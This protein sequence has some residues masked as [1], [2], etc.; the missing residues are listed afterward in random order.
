MYIF[1]RKLIILVC[2]FSVSVVG[3]F[4]ACKNNTVSSTVE[5]NTEITAATVHHITVKNAY[6]SRSND[7][8]NCDVDLTDLGEP[9]RKIV[10]CVL[11]KECPLFS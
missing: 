10:E 3:V 2:S 1:K 4:K 5:R 9:M 7:L 6:N 11:R 8:L